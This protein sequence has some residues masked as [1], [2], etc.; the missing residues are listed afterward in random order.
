MH[1][2]NVGG[3]VYRD[4][5]EERLYGV[6]EFLVNLGD[7]TVVALLFPWLLED[8]PWE[9]VDIPRMIEVDVREFQRNSS[10]GLGKRVDEQV[11]SQRDGGSNRSL[12]K[13]DNR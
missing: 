5:G 11:R 1:L 2:A 8:L 4:I 6:N 7:E 13:R 12:A 9:L 3:L 10:L